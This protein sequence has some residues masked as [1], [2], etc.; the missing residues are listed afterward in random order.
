MKTNALRMATAV[1]SLLIG[2]L[3]DPV[4]SSKAA[5]RNDGGFSFVRLSPGKYV[6]HQAAQYGHRHIL[7]GNT[8]LGFA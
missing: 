4:N 1:T 7:G 2:T 6:R 3:R 5:R 8:H